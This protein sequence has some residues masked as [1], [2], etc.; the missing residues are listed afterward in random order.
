MLSMIQKKAAAFRRIRKDPVYFIREYLGSEPWP[1]QAE[2]LEAV[3]DH[4]EVAVASCH[5]AGKS[6]ISRVLGQFPDLSKDT[7]IPLSWITAAQNRVLPEGEP[8]ILGCDIARQGSD[9]TVI[10]LRRGPVAR[11]FK[12]T[13][14]EDTMKTTGRIISALAKTGATEARIDAVGIGA[15]VFDRLQE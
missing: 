14:Q 3:R 1:K 7:L 12:A 9:E 5:A 4:K 6:W 15:G 8:T 11:L 2:I 10:M 13:K